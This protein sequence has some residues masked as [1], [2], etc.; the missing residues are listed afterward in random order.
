MAFVTPPAAPGSAGAEGLANRGTR[1]VER[2]SLAA[3]LIGSLAE[4]SL[5]L[6]PGRSAG[7]AHR[8]LLGGRLPIEEEPQIID[9]FAAVDTAPPPPPASPG[10]D[11][12]P[13][14]APSRRGRRGGDPDDDGLCR[15]R[16]HCAAHRRPPGRRLTWRCRSRLTALRGRATRPALPPE[17]SRSLRYLFDRRT[18]A[19]GSVMFGHGIHGGDARKPASPADQ[20]QP[21]PSAAPARAAVARRS[22]PPVNKPQPGQVDRQMPGPMTPSPQQLSPP[23]AGRTNPCRR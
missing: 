12:K 13:T 7:G 18:R 10:F 3:R 19:E 23:T 6:T 21:G 2:Q 22:R 11:Q 15:G 8:R 16:R 14:S 20:Q 4:S 17:G 5:P 9:Y 1:R